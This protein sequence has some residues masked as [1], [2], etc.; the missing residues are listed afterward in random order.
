MMKTLNKLMLVGLLVVSGALNAGQPSANP[1]FPLELVADYLGGNPA[2]ASYN[3][4]MNAGIT[5]GHANGIAIGQAQA[6]AANAAST[7]RA[8]NNPVAAGFSDGIKT[9]IATTI[10]VGGG[11]YLLKRL[12]SY[13]TG[14]NDE[15]KVAKELTNLTAELSLLDGQTTSIRKD[16]DF[17]TTIFNGGNNVGKTPEDIKKM[18]AA[19][20]EQIDRLLKSLVQNSS[21]KEELALKINDYRKQLVALKKAKG[22]Q[23]TAPKTFGQV[24]QLPTTT[25]QATPAM[26]AKML[27]ESKARAA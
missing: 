12:A 18:K 22:D 5:L 14:E 19:C 1:D 9:L 15:E 13:V 25:K 2:S 16:L 23:A 26:A 11:T 7:P 8:D 27:A 20:Q 17:Y 24:A 6:H 21:E 3:A 4:G 10:I